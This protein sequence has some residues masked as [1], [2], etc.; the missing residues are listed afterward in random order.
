[1]FER[2]F[3]AY[4]AGQVDAEILDQLYGYR[5]ANI[6]A[7]NRIVDVKLQNDYLKKYWKRLI[8]LTYVLEA[9][10]GKR[11]PLHTDRY[12]PKDLFDQRSTRNI[13]QKL[14]SR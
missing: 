13:L 6:W 8:A 10:R 3:I 14:E 7:N 1:M 4:Q 11:F 9:H 2:I 12:F 5:I